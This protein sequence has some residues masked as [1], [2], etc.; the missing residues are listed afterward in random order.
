ME[1]VFFFFSWLTYIHW[2][3]NQPVS[4]KLLKANFSRSKPDPPKNPR[5]GSPN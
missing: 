3:L 5:F 2:S 4:F 1:S